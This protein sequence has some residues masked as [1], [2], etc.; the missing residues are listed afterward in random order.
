[1]DGL[2]SGIRLAL[3][4]LGTA[5]ASVRLW[6][7]AWL[8]VS[9]PALLQVWPLWAELKQAFDHYPNPHPGIT[10]TLNEHLDPD[11]AR[12]HPGLRMEF[13]GAS[14]VVMLVWTFLAGGILCR[15]GLGR[16]TA[17]QFLADCGRCLPRN[18]RA[19]FVGLVLLLLLCWGVDYFDAWLKGDVL[20]DTDPGTSA[21]VGVESRFLTLESGLAALQWVYGA[22]FLLVLF[23]GKMA[24]ASLCLQNRHSALLAWLRAFLRMLRHP[25]RTVTALLTI[26]L[27]WIG[28]G[29][30]LRIAMDYVDANGH[31]WQLLVLSQ[32]FAVMLQLI[33]IA[34]LLVARDLMVPAAAVVET[35]PLPDDE[36]L[37]LTPVAER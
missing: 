6:L 29:F 37:Q 34:T 26:G 4:S 22:L 15:V 9:V 31:S 27:V 1:M 32:A 7:L 11:F 33:T 3:R 17:S 28:T 25:F 13:T 30:L 12:Q 23:A 21:A 16:F 2:M 8:L 36:V 20:A 14:L 18:L 19:M 5:L 10:L 24:R 35:G